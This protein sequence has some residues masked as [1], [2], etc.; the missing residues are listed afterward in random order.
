MPVNV[1]TKFTQEREQRSKRSRHDG[2]MGRTCDTSGRFNLEDFL[3]AF[4]TWHSVRN[5]RPLGTGN[6]LTREDF[7]AMVA[8]NQ[9]DEGHGG[10]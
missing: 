3:R 7:V 5:N 1:T 4:G 10:K 9:G 6:E 8:L 2:G